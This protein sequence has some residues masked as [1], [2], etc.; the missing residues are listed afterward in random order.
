[1][2]YLR[3]SSPLPGLWAVSDGVAKI[4]TFSVERCGFIV[5]PEPGQVVGRDALSSIEAFILRRKL[6]KPNARIQRDSVAFLERL[7]TLEDPRR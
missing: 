4:A 5:V 1:M 2:T 6:N 7:Y 3:F